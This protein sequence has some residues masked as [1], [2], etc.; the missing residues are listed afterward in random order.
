VQLSWRLSQEADTA[1]GGGSAAQAAPEND[2]E[3]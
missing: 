2:E 1:S 3:K